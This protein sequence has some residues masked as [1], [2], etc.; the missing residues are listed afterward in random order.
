MPERF[1]PRDR[2]LA[3][4]VLVVGQ[5]RLDSDGAAA[6]LTAH[7]F[8]AWFLDFETLAM[9]VPIWK[10]SRPYGQVRFQFSPHRV[11][12]DGSIGHE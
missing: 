6:A 3:E 11:G 12:E 5:T 2:H 4:E 1:L 10:G 8:P 7:G 9:P